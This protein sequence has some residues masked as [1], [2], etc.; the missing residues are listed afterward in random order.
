MDEALFAVAI[1]LPRRSSATDILRGAV[2]D[3]TIER[4]A[5]A[6]LR[7]AKAAAAV[8]P[9]PALGS[10]C[11]ALLGRY[12]AAACVSRGATISIS[13]CLRTLAAPACAAARLGGRGTAAACPDATLALLLFAAGLGGGDG[14]AL[15]LPTLG[16]AVSVT[17]GADAA[18]E[19]LHGPL[20]AALRKRCGG[21]GA[22]AGDSDDDGGLRLLE[23]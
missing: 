14:G 20:K 8:V 7:A 21:R 10:A 2:V 17:G 4:A 13:G 12:A 18:L 9:L 11:R 15:S 1:P 16:D 19:G 5:V 23:P 22:P 6:A 3:A